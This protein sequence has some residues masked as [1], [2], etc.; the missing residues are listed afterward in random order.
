VHLYFDYLT[1]YTLSLLPLS[2]ISVLIYFLT[3]GDSYP[4]FYA[5]V[6]S[7]YSTIFVAVWR[8][9]ERKLAVRWG[10]RGSE[11]VAVSRL[12]PEYVAKLG[13]DKQHASGEGAVD[14]IQAGNDLRRDVKVAASVPI[15]ILCGVGL[16]VV[17]MGIFLL[18]AFVAQVYDGVGKQVVVSAQNGLGFLESN[19]DSRP[20]PR[21]DG[22]VRACRAADRGGVPNARKGA[23]QVGGPPYP[24]WRRE[25]SD[26][27]DLVSA[28][29]RLSR[30]GLMRSAM[31]GI[32]AYLGLFLS[33]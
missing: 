18:E 4:P 31:N 12:R 2:L 3:P 25:E 29:A 32:V 6:L 11:S 26:G 15:I 10:T 7:L 33:A 19:G 5:F 20:A 13:L 23:R 16:G 22:D 28:S 21:P 8:I 17:L 30:T 9:K 27:K 14:T 24:G 1:T